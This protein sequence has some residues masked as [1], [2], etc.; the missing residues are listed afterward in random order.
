MEGFQMEKAQQDTD[1]G[2]K[3]PTGRHMSEHSEDW[4]WREIPQHFQK[5]KIK[6]C[7][8]KQEEL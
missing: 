7:K 2:W 5:K 8:I 6:I 3:K 1:K 4:E